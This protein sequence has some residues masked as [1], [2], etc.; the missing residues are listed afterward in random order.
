LQR[1][2]RVHRDLQ[3]EVREVVLEQDQRLVDEHNSVPVAKFPG[4]GKERC[5]IAVCGRGRGR[6]TRC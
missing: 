5:E 4:A 3:R 1:V 2:D 6:L